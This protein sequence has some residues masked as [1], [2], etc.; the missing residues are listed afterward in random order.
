MNEN[1]DDL[2]RTPE[3]RRYHR[4]WLKFLDKQLPMTEKRML[5]VHLAFTTGWESVAKPEYW[6]ADFIRRVCDGTM[7][8]VTNGKIN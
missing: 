8:V 2:F 5:Q 3:L 6:S 1:D 4:A 7:P